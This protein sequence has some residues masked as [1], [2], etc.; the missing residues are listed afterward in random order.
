ML[1]KELINKLGYSVI[2]ND[3]PWRKA[4]IPP[5]MVDAMAALIMQ[6][7]MSGIDYYLHHVYVQ[8]ANNLAIG[9]YFSQVQ[10]P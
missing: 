10:L 7:Y 1:T 8:I 2:N 4:K 6:L 3:T 9:L 5:Y